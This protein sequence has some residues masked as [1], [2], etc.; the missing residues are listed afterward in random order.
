[1][2]LG[3]SLNID[4]TD[5]LY[6]KDTAFN[7]MC[8]LL[9][10]KFY[11]K[12]KKEIK[13]RLSEGFDYLPPKLRLLRLDGYPMRRLPSQ[14]CPKSLVKLQMRESNL[15]KLWEGVHVSFW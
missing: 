15:E 6:I 12:R 3:I 11:T 14:F 4:E 1:M 9:F 2:V 10:L 8:N 5:E 13:W 7:G